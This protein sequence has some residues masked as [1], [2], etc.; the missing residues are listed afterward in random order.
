[1]G[2][3]GGWGFQL[4][5]EEISSDR[6]GWCGGGVGAGAGAG[7][8]VVLVLVAGGPTCSAGLG[9]SRGSYSVLDLRGHGHEGL[10]GQVGVAELHRTPQLGPRA[11][12]GTPQGAPGGGTGWTEIKVWKYLIGL[13]STTIPLSY[14]H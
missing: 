8:G 9:G 10:G 5:M 6:D 3:E 1:M 13:E 2:F 12:A 11:A 14:H 7:A 4:S